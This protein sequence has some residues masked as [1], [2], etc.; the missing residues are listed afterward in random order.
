MKTCNGSYEEIK[1][2]KPHSVTDAMVWREVQP[3]FLFRFCVQSCHP[4][5][6]SCDL[7]NKFQKHSDI[8]PRA[9]LPELLV[10]CAQGWS[11]TYGEVSTTAN[12]CDS[13]DDESLGLNLIC[14]W[15]WPR[16]ASIQFVNSAWRCWYEFSPQGQIIWVTNGLLLWQEQK[17]ASVGRNKPK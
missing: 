7:K 14:L 12:R 4:E 1:K 6:I 11:K 3:I 13:L 2:P 17:F 16:Q 8:T 10:L 15:F 5:K 9:R